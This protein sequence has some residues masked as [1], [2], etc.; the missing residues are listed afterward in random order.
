[1]PGI[2]LTCYNNSQIAVAIRGEPLKRF[3]FRIHRYALPIGLPDGIKV[4]VIIVP[5]ANKVVFKAVIQ[6]GECEHKVIA[7]PLLADSIYH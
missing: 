3:I 1:M 2:T 6:T 5:S 4:A 7:P